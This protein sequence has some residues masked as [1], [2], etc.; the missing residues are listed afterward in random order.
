MIKN[1]P[2]PYRPSQDFYSDI[3]ISLGFDLVPDPI[4]HFGLLII[5]VGMKY[6]DKKN[7]KDITMSTRLISY[8][9]SIIH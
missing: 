8:H 7:R 2:Y 6:M 1:I 9:V 4:Y 3:E 5:K